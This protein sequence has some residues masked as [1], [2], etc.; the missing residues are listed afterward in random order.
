MQPTASAIQ[1]PFIPNRGFAVLAGCF[2]LVSIVVETAYS[3]GRLADAYFLVKVVGWILI[4]W[5]ATRI[6]AGNP[7]GL[8]YLAAGWGWMGANFWR[9]IADRLTDISAG[10]TLRLGSI[11][12]A[13]TGSCLTVCVAGL[14]LTLVN[15]N[16]NDR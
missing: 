14:I 5:G 11:E 6:R 1:R 3:W 7:R 4:A 13:F 12:I 15:A 10:Q 9:A 2:L 16:R 8:T